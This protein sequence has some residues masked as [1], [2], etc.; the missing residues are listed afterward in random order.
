MVGSHEENNGDIDIKNIKKIIEDDV[1]ML[2]ISAQAYRNEILAA[3]EELKGLE[4]NRSEIKSNID[5]DILAFRDKFE[6]EEAHAMH[7]IK[8]ENTRIEEKDKKSIEKEKAADEALT[9]AISMENESKDR[10]A[11]LNVAIIDVEREQREATILTERYEERLESVQKQSN[12]LAEKQTALDL[13]LESNLERAGSLDELQKDLE[14]LSREL[15]EKGKD[16]DS[17]AA[18]TLRVEKLQ[19]KTE[20]EQRQKAIDLN[21]R[22]EDLKAAEKLNS[23]T[24]SA[25]HAGQEN[26]KK[27]KEELKLK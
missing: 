12:D 15:S 9:T 14:R 1:K 16:V 24:R 4:Q 17:L 13:L 23:E 8:Q 7:I 22:E 6:K 26:L 25:L 20:H 10:Q 11:K 19:T 27:L 18:T 5:K 3:K 21:K 2:E